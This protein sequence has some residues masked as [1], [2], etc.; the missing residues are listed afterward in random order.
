MSSTKAKLTRLILGQKGGEN[1]LRILRMLSERPSNTNQLAVALDLSYNTTQ[2]HIKILLNNEI[3]T[4]SESSS[5]G[6]VFFLNPE[7]DSDDELLNEMKRVLNLNKADV[8]ENE[9]E[10]SLIFENSPVGMV[11]VNNDLTISKLNRA[12]K[13]VIHFDAG[14]I[15]G[16]LPGEALRCVKHFES[17][18]GCG[19]SEEC[20]ICPIRAAMSDTVRTGKAYNMI[21]ASLD[22]KKGKDILTVHLV[23]S[24]TPIYYHGERKVLLTIHHIA[25]QNED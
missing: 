14:D 8:L 23:L 19:T 7:L 2:Y 22:I 18:D 17:P 12:A 20:H 4:C 25:P 21:E 13:S 5:Y 9:D 15:Q 6:C 3:I 11:M 24:T 16:K 10:L 1:R